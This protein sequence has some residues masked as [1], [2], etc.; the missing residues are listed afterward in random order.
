[1]DGCRVGSWVVGWTPSSRP[2][3][4]LQACVSVW[5]S[6]DR[7]RCR[8]FERHQ[9]LFAIRA[10]RR[11]CSH[12]TVPEAPPCHVSSWRRHQQR[13]PSR[14]HASC[15]TRHRDAVLAR[16]ELVAPG[17]TSAASRM[18][19]VNGPDG[20]EH[21]GCCGSSHRFRVGRVNTLTGNSFDSP[22]GT[23]GSTFGK[24]QGFVR[25]TERSKPC[26]RE[27]G[28]RVE[29]ESKVLTSFKLS[30]AS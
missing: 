2:P 16:V 9:G 25:T 24:N 14:I 28:N 8:A 11:G 6:A 13:R 27:S 23:A 5:R 17:A 4:S 22:A 18:F 29:I 20:R 21:G 30:S 7:T 15:H 3:C 1:M 12:D 19:R 26:Q 10:S